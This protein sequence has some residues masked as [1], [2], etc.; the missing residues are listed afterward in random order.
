MFC[1]HRMSNIATLLVVFS[2]L[3]FKLCFL[4]SCSP[5]FPGSPKHFFITIS[6]HS[7]DGTA[8]ESFA[9]RLSE[10]P[11]DFLWVCPLYFA[12]LR[13]SA[14]IACLRIITREDSRR[15]PTPQSPALRQT[16][17]L[18]CR[19]GEEDEGREGNKGRGRQIGW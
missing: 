16:P 19:S 7:V 9:L 17:Q 15:N 4:F 13:D 2:V 1:N 10:E 3:L 11:R 6:A 14:V 8:G 5:V 12:P 18:Q